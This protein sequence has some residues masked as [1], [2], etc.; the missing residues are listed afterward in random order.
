M[1]RT[2]P[3]YRCASVTSSSQVLSHGSPSKDLLRN[4]ARGVGMAGDHRLNTLDEG[5]HLTAGRPHVLQGLG[6][7]R[8][9]PGL[10]QGDAVVPGPAGDEI[11][12]VPALAAVL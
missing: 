2:F 6:H 3:E 7:D 12:A 8:A 9:Q 5:R 1:S 10:R 4:V 11:A